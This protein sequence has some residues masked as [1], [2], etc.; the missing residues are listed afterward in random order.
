MRKK[1]SL[2]PELHSCWGFALLFSLT[3]NSCME[4]K[5]AWQGRESPSLR[6]H[7]ATAGCT[8]LAEQGHSPMHLGPEIASPW[9]PAAGGSGVLSVNKAHDLKLTHNMT[10]L[11]R[12]LPNRKK[13]VIAHLFYLGQQAGLMLISITTDLIHMFTKD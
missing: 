7:T 11:Q 10:Y 9:P 4:C 5:A 2:S 6:S 8:L 1:S 3:Q 13:K 12:W